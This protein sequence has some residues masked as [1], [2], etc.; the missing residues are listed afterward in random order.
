MTL[1]IYFLFVLSSNYIY[2]IFAGSGDHW[3]YEDYG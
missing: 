2:E 3:N 1:K